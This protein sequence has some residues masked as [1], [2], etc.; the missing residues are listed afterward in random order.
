MITSGIL[1]INKEKGITSH[2]VVERVRR[3]LRGCKVGHAGTLDPL[4]TGV[5]VVLVGQAVRIS[6]YV[7]DLPKIYRATITLGASTDTYDSEGAVTSTGPIDVTKRRLEAGLAEFAGDI[8]Q[9]PP[10]YSAAKIDGTR[11]YRL[12]RKG[13]PIA[14]KPRTVH[15]YRLD[16][17]RFATP[18]VEI[19]IECAKG[20]YIR[21]IAHDLGVALSC[22]AHVSKLVRTRV[23]PF[24]VDTALGSTDLPSA[25]QDDVL[26]SHLRPTDLG[27]AHLPSLTAGIEDEKDL[28]HG[29]AVEMND[30][31]LTPTVELSDGLLARGYA[32]DGRLLGILRFESGTGLWRPHKIFNQ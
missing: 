4:A 12:A 28:R 5:L 7:M 21:S 1:N 10:P 6:E 23:G 2:D 31:D 27:L 3:G 13:T 20:T 8:Q 11:A 30:R 18:N 22:G 17:L 14:P 15:V 25:L 24:D 29:Q 16:L 32:E 26:E 19:E 9:T